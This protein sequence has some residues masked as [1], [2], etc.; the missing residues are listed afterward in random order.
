MGN[1]GLGKDLVNREDEADFLIIN[2]LEFDYNYRIKI[3]LH[4]Q[5]FRAFHRKVAFDET[6]MDSVK[7][8]F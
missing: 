7:S 1:S 4:S 8:P 5:G 3:L 2:L 6:K